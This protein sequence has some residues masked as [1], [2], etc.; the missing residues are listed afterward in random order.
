MSRGARDVAPD[1]EYDLLRLG[2]DVES[3]SLGSRLHP[4]MAEIGVRRS[5]SSR[6]RRRGV[7]GSD[8][9]DGV[10]AC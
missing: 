5:S 3:G 7:S 8:G 2:R 1:G 10:I 9:E 4:V 6:M